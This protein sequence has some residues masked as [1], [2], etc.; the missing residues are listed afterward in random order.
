MNYIENDKRLEEI[1]EDL[2]FFLENNKSSKTE[3][4]QEVEKPVKI[5]MLIYLVAI[6]HNINWNFL[7][8][9]AIP[10]LRD[11]SNSFD[12]NILVNINEK[13][14]EEIFE[15]YPKK[16]KVEA[17]RRCDMIKEVARYLKENVDLIDQIQNMTSLEGE[18]GFFSCMNKM[19]VFEEDPLHKKTNLLAQLLI[20]E[21]IL[22]VEDIYHMIPLVDYHIIRLYLRT[23]RIKIVNKEIEDN[24]RKEQPL[25]LS[26]IT[27]LRR[28]IAEQIQ[29]FCEK[30]QKTTDELNQYEWGI[31][32]DICKKEE[33]KC[34]KC[35]LK[36]HCDSSMKKTKEM[37]IEPV[38]KSGFY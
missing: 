15:E 34:K 27:Q 17:K 25:T 19:K 5:K 6:C 29:R 22:K 32:R 16:E 30:H 38:D 28:M 2:N 23:G 7:M 10:K 35:V 12:Y 37:L 9:H 33:A 14:V 1:I 3:L 21:Q 13:T 18:N 36:E 24:I 8:D 4:Y 31:A 26:Q 11:I 20:E